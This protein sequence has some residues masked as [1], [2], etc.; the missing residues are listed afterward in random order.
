VGEKLEIEKLDLT[1][2]DIDDE[3]VQILVDGLA[4]CRN[5]ADLTLSNNPISVIGLRSLA[6]LFQSESCRLVRL[7][8]EYVD[9]DDDGA[10]VLAI[11][12]K[13]C[14]LLKSLNLSNNIIG[15]EGVAA[16]VSGITTANGNLEKLCLSYNRFSVAG[17]RSLSTLIQAE[18]STLE[19]LL[20]D[21]D[22]N[23]G[24]DAAAVLADALA[25]NTSLV[26][27]RLSVRMIN[28]VQENSQDCFVTL[29]AST[30]FTYQIILWGQSVG[31]TH[32]LTVRNI[33]F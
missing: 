11:I 14:K 21:G 8:L 32:L 1:S 27:L 26:Y 16:L 33:L 31:T 24:D 19:T 18:K 9:I 10:E 25:N 2:V 7:E 5:L 13:T 6:T 12:L 15:D 28:A 20:I 17:M 3:C 29:L 22:I 30:I 4:H 23:I